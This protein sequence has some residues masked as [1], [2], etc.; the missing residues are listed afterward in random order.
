ME[1]RHVGRSGL[2]TSLIGL[3]CNN[4]GARL[5][6]DTSRAVV[7]AALDAG[8][9]MFDTADSYGL[10]ASE[11]ILGEG[12]EGRRD[13]VVIATKF[14][15]PMGEGPYR[16]GAS[17][18]YIVQACEASLRRLRTDYIDLYYLHFPDPKTPL[19][20]TLSALDHLVTQG[21]VRYLG[22]SN[23]AGWQITDAEH[24]A[25]AAGTSRF[26]ASQF[27]WNLVS[28]SAEAEVV[29]ACA[30]AGV[31]VIPFFPLAAG[32]LSGK[33]RA[34]E[35]FPS[36]SR[37]AK[38]PFFAKLATDERLERIEVLRRFAEDRG[39]HL[40]DLAMSWMAAQ[41]SVACVLAGA[42]RPEQVRANADAV[43]AWQLSPEELA[44][45]DDATQPA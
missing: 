9:T 35:A 8:Y 15:S 6:E 20:E 38:H 42:S 25:R 31:G 36:D 45:I 21:K 28:R 7:A 13:E 32:L 23:F 19:E 10:G 41:P 2:V 33:Y 27:E 17:R 30:H 26:V 34:G 11:A 24:L 22:S 40:I 16:R 18:T 3:G 1:Y 39:R 43:V 14:S 37:L 12:L 4:L 5:D 29:P 44:A